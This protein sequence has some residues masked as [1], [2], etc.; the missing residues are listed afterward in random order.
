MGIVNPPQRNL[1]LGVG[2]IGESQQ[3]GFADILA[4]LIAALKAHHFVGDAGHGILHGGLAGHEALLNV[5]LGGQ[6]GAAALEQAQLNP[7][8]LGP[9]FLLAGLG[10]GGGQTAQLGMAKTVGGGGLG[11]GDEGAV[12][13]VN[14]LGDSYHAVSIRLIDPI[15]V[16]EE[17][18]HVEVHLGEIHQVG[19]RAVN[20]GQGR[21][22]SQPAGVTAHNLDNADHAG[23]IDPGVLIDLHAACGDIL[24]G[25]GKTGAVVG[26]K[27]VVV[28]GLGHAHHAALIAHFLHILAD[29][30]AGIH[31]VVA[32]VVEEVADIVLLKNLQNALIVRI[33]HIRVRHLVAAGAQGGGGSVLQQ[34]Q[35]GGVLLAH[36]KQAVVQNALDAVLRTQHPGDVGIVQSGTDYAVGAGVDDRGGSSGLTKDTGAFQFTHEKNL[37]KI[38]VVPYLKTVIVGMAYHIIEKKN[39][40]YLHFIFFVILFSEKNVFAFSNAVFANL[41]GVP[42][43]CRD[44][45]GKGGRNKMRR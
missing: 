28:D 9:G 1:L 45:I 24:G 7:P 35:L 44:R 20:A 15:H 14:A 25:G 29:L 19:A 22:A 32:A 26:A 4:A 34:L 31:G 6:V 16:I 2:H 11:L 38:C 37:L 36:V 23:I 13:V 3:L 17:L 27:E 30:V 18:L 33:V 40:K 43:C 39:C 42:F 21:G 41:T 12:G 10:Q 5:G 8:D